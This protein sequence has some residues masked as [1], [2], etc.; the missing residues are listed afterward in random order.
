VTRTAERATRRVRIDN[1][2]VERGLAP[3]RE[4]ARALVMAGAVV[5]RDRNSGAER[6]VDKPGTLVALDTDVGLRVADHPYVSRGGV[7]LAAALERFG[8][9]AT[10]GIALDAG[11][12][13]GGFTDCLLRR[14]ARQVIAVDVGYGQFAWSLRQDPRVVLFER[15]NL[16][17]LRPEVLPAA[18][19]LVV[20]DVSFIS[21]RLILGHVRLLC[22][23]GATVLPL[24]KPQFE[25][26]KGKVGKGGVVRDPALRARAVTD[27]AAAAAV[28]GYRV[29]GQMDSP[30]PGPKG[31][32]ETF[33]HLTAPRRTPVER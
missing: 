21:L 23:P 3:S 9:D 20:V 4:R 30:L 28:L 16:R 33:L 2:I 12:S 8:V 32:V 14:G 19:G 29:R 31:N 24:V 17:H 11:A 6:L 1:L 18:P 26:G 10:G 5:V 15:Q 22:T 13:T 27:V 25:V 7:K